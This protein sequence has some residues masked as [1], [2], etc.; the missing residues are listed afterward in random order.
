MKGVFGGHKRKDCIESYLA[1]WVWGERRALGKRG[2]GRNCNLL[3]SPLNDWK[4]NG[5]LS[6]D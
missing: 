1:S 5:P 6:G 3:V 4:N 2:S